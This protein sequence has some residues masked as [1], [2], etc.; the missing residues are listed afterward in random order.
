[1]DSQEIIIISDDSEEEDLKKI[2]SENSFEDINKVFENENIITLSSDDNEILSQSPSTNINDSDSKN[3]CIENEIDDSLEKTIE[4]INSIKNSLY[5]Q[6]KESFRN[7]KDKLKENKAKKDDLTK[8]IN[9]IK[10]LSIKNINSKS[11]NNYINQAKKCI[12]KIENKNFENF[13]EFRKNK[14][15]FVFDNYF[16][17]IEKEIKLKNKK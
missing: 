16:N 14:M 12:K 9:F 1:M 2:E 4:R 17:K 5:N 11:L 13:S 15:I 7:Y 10:N 8:K 3:K 6:I